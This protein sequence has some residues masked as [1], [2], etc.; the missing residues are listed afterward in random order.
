TLTRLANSIIP[1]AIILVLLFVNTL[2]QVKTQLDV[3]PWLAYGTPPDIHLTAAGWYG[4]MVSATIFQFLLGL[5]IWK[6]LLWTIFAFRLSRLDLHL[7]ATHPDRNGGLGFLGLVPLA[8]APISFAT[9][10]AI[11]ATWRHEILDHG[12]NLMSYRTDAIVLLIIV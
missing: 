5:S 3:V 12:A 10:A 2:T 7:I 4:I 11:G 1:E 8:F 6:W 9:A